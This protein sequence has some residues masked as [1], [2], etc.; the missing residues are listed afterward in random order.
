[1]AAFLRVIH[2]IGLISTT[3][4]TIY[5]VLT[6]RKPRPISAWGKLLSIAISL[7]LLYFFVIISGA[8]LN[9]LVGWPLLIVGGL[10]G[11]IRGLTLRFSFESDQVIAR[12]SWLFLLVWGGSWIVAQL[13]N[14]YGTRLLA[15]IGLM[16]VFFSTGIQLGLDGILLLRRLLFRYKP[17]PAMEAAS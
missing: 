5:M 7:A 11:L 16:P 9:P 13:F 17:P 15:S 10:L 2:Y 3:V 8:R 1:M 12:G 14:Y 4:L 6:F